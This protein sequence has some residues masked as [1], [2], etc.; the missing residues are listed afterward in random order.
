MLF[1]ALLSLLVIFDPDPTTSMLGVIGSSFAAIALFLIP[2][3]PLQRKIQAEKARELTRIRGAI[4]R[5]KEKSVEDHE[6]WA[7]RA[8][9]SIYAQQIEQVSTWA[10]NTP[11]VVR[12]ALYVS[13]GIG[14]W[15]GAAFV[16]RS[17]GTLLG[18]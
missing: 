18:P 15:V 2:L 13:L 17:L 16:E 8:D 4:L 9:L 11:T 3:I 14:S 1:M 5:E 7:P 6:D 12:F 10:L